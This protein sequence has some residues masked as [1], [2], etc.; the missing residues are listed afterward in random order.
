MDLSTAQAEFSPDTVFLNTASVGLPPARTLTALSA[1][2]DE[3]RLGRAEPPVYDGFVNH[4]REVYAALVGVPV[5][6]VAIG[7]QASPLVGLV[8]ASVPDGVEIVVA[9][10]DFTSVIYPFLAQRGRGVQVRAVPLP[11]IA[12]ALTESTHLVAVSGVQSADGAI[13]DADALVSAATAND[14]RTLVDLTQAT[15]WLTF[16]ATQFDYTVCSA[17][18]WLLS[19]RGTAFLT[20]RPS[21]LDGVVPH[22]AGWYAGE[23]V[24][25]SIYGHDMRLAHSARRLDTSPAWLSW[26]GTAESLDFLTEVGTSLLHRHAVGQA[27]RFLEGV[28]LPPGDGAIVSLAA[29]ADVPALMER[30]RIRAAVRAGRLRLSFHIS[31]TDADVETAIAALRGHVAS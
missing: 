7:H 14:V 3:W 4:A 25:G 2:M 8:A 13:I 27:N 15:G 30:H 29:D 24:W 11:E 12:S 31:T 22:A 6:W 26:V 28:G 17:Y 5:D 21:L 19:P 10:G 9:E 18:K 23:D 1:A 16:D 20:V